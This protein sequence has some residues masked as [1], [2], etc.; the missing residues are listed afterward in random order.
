MRAAVFSGRSRACRSRTG[1]AHARPAATQS[2]PPHPH[3]TTALPWAAALFPGP[4]RS[5]SDGYVWTNA[6][7][8]VSS[9]A[10]YNPPER[11]V[12]WPGTMTTPTPPTP[13]DGQPLLAQMAAWIKRREW[14]LEGSEDASVRNGPPAFRTWEDVAGA[15]PPHLNRTLDS[16]NHQSRQSNSHATSEGAVYSAP[17][18]S[19]PSWTSRGNPP[20]QMG[21]TRTPAASPS[22]TPRL[23]LLVRN[24]PPRAGD[25]S[26][27]G[28]RD[29]NSQ[30]FTGRSSP[31]IGGL[32]TGMP[33]NSLGSNRRNPSS[34]SLLMRPPMDQERAVAWHER[35]YEH[36]ASYSPSP[37][38]PPPAPPMHGQPGGG[39]G[40]RIRFGGHNA[41]YTA[42]LYVYRPPQSLMPLSVISY[43]ERG[44]ELFELPAWWAVLRPDD[45][46][47]V[48]VLLRPGPSMP[49]VHSSGTFVLDCAAAASGKLCCAIVGIAPAQAPLGVDEGLLS[50]HEEVPPHNVA[51]AVRLLLEPHSGRTVRR[52]LAGAQRLGIAF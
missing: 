5:Q 47:L 7:E 20:S 31:L 45:C 43:D 8:H 25:V 2:S 46:P 14:E 1:S 29:L 39:L 30:R 12:P 41:D 42:D 21:G 44:K 52:W 37:M 6:V 17:S 24:Q 50:M 28:S 3:I 34:S 15:S 33:M 26:P 51:M 22:Q 11:N 10:A 13:P 18:C 23:P 32:T 36:M 40:V 19:P 27:L 38:P 4:E 48:W 35:E 49:A 9:T 16:A